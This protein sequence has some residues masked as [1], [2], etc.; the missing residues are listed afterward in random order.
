M[1]VHHGLDPWII[2]VLYFSGPCYTS[3]IA[4]VTSVQVPIILELHDLNL[5]LIKVVLHWDFL[6]RGFVQ[7]DS[8]WCPPVWY[9]IIP[10]LSNKSEDKS[11]DKCPRLRGPPVGQ[12]STAAQLTSRL[13]HRKERRVWW[14]GCMNNSCLSLNVDF[15]PRHIPRKYYS[16]KT[17]FEKCVFQWYTLVKTH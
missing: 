13:F 14:N 8:K 3:L 6:S 2:E 12:H 11:E 15:R 7:L 17:S 9:K 16:P 1:R 4:H 5:W 10:S